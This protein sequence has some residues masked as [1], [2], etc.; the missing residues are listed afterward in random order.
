M[1]RCK[2]CG[3]T[4]RCL[5]RNNNLHHWDHQQCYNCHYFRISSKGYTGKSTGRYGEA[6]VRGVGWSKGRHFPK[7][8][9]RITKKNIELYCKLSKIIRDKPCTNPNLTISLQKLLKPDDKIGE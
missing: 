7:H 3:F 4:I 9:I 8:K 1:L 6:R 2:T 5:D